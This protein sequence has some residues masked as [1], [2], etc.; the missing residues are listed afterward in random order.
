MDSVSAKRSMQ[1]RNRILL[2]LYDHPHRPHSQQGSLLPPVTYDAPIE[3]PSSLLST[4]T[5]E[6]GGAKFNSSHHNDPR[7]GGGRRDS[8]GFL[9]GPRR[10]PPRR[11]PRHGLRLH[12]AGTPGDS[13]EGSFHRGASIAGK[14]NHCWARRHSLGFVDFAPNLSNC[15]FLT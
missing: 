14:S 11:C 9:V 4:L 6:S 5:N 7:G 13:D 10:V 15:F 2:L 8:L 12:D 1:R 3:R